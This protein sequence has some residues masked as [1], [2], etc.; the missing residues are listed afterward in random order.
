MSILIGLWTQI[1]GL[2]GYLHPELLRLLW[3]KWYLTFWRPAHSGHTFITEG[4]T[5][6]RLS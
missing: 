3:S 2:L 5:N 4:F 6:Q 1:I